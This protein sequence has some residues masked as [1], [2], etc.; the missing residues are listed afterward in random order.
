VESS[1]VGDTP[2]I[3]KKL[4]KEEKG[5]KVFLSTIDLISIIA[6]ETSKIVEKLKIEALRR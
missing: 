2:V 6:P 3:E 4:V 5:V 1:L